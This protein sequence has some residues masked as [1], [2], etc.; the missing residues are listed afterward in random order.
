LAP[1]I[2][3][4]LFTP[5]IT[6]LLYSESDLFIFC[7]PTTFLSSDTKFVFPINAPVTV[8]ISCSTNVFF[9]DRYNVTSDDKMKAFVGGGCASIVGQ[10]KQPGVNPTIASYNAGV[11]KIYNAAIA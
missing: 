11:V 7:R 6:I 1:R 8:S 5:N 10:V 2:A 9:Q 4:G 3:L